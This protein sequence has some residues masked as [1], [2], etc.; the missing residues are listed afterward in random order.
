M[1]KKFDHTLETVPEKT[2]VD[3]SVRSDD[4]KLESSIS[5]DSINV[6]M[7]KQSVTGGENPQTSQSFPSK[8]DYQYPPNSNKISEFSNESKHLEM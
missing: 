6:S 5:K 2:E 3:S 4:I 7:I 1:S 8:T